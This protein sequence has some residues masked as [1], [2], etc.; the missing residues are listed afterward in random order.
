MEIRELIDE[1]YNLI[2]NP[3]TKSE[4]REILVAFKDG[5]T[6]KTDQNRAVMEL[7]ANLRQLAV[8]NLSAE[9]K[10]SSGVADL[11]QKISSF[12]EQSRNL[13]QGLASTGVWLNGLK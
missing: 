10:L 4:E 5:L 2:L 9:T 12:G 6:D 11:Y 7:S 1:V 13:A 3:D 8:K